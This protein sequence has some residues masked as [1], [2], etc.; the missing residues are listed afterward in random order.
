MAQEQPRRLQEVQDHI[1]GLRRGDP[2]R[3][4]YAPFA[5]RRRLFA[6]DGPRHLLS[7]LR[8]QPRFGYRTAQLLRRNEPFGHQHDHLPV[9]HR[10]QAHVHLPRGAGGTRLPVRGLLLADQGPEQRQTGEHLVES[11]RHP[12]ERHHRRQLRLSVVLRTRRVQ[13][14]RTVTT[15]TSRCVPTAPRA[16][17]PRTAGPA[18][19]R[20]ASCGT[21]ATRNSWRTP[22]AG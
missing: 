16:S 13:L 20:W 8:P 6:L 22:A 9:R 11:A 14:F 18:S 1:H 21:C 19:G 12:L 17:A 5:V 7:E 3:R 2:D 4:A 15:P 10:Q